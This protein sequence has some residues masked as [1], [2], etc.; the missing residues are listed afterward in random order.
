MDTATRH[1]AKPNKRGEEWPN[2]AL[3]KV[4][5]DQMIVRKETD[6]CSKQAKKCRA[7]QHADGRGGG[8]H[9]P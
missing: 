5:D 7:L 3:G 4:D 6:N 8:P 9:M 2:I 1:A